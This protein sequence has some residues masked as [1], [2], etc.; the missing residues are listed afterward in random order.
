MNSSLHNINNIPVLKLAS[1]CGWRLAFP[2]QRWA[3]G[4]VSLLIVVVIPV[5][6]VVAIAVS[7]VVVVV[8]VTIASLCTVVVVVVVPISGGSRARTSP[9]ACTS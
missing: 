9:S 2:E 1:D 7:V 8:V 4:E 5:A 3:R 6:V